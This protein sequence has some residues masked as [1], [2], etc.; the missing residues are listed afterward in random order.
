MYAF[1][2][3]DELSEKGTWRPSSDKAI[4]ACA[5]CGNFG[6]LGKHEISPEGRITPS[7][8]CPWSPCTFH[9]YGILEGW[10]PRD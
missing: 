8:V 7:I 3:D 10:R 9:D 5:S 6:G 4:I 2:R 1:K